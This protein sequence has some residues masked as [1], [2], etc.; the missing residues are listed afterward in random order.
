MDPFLEAGPSDKSDFIVRGIYNNEEDKVEEN[1]K[2]VSPE[3]GDACGSAG[4]NSEEA[5]KSFGIRIPVKPSKQ[6]V[7]EHER[8][9]LPFRDWCKHY[10]YG[11]GGN[12]PHNSRKQDEENSNPKTFWDNMYM[13]EELH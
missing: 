4:Q 3:I 6:E 9:H 5:R 2:A 7:E 1:A 8:T 11:R 13:H 10:V 12:L